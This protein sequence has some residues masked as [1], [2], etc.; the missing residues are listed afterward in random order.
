MSALEDKSI[1]PGCKYSLILAYRYE[2]VRWHNA[3]WHAKCAFED[4]AAENVRLQTELE[5]ARGIIRAAH[6]TQLGMIKL[7]EKNSM[8]HEALDMFEKKQA[9]WLASH[10]ADRK[11]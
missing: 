7:A 8:P 11:R 3:E 9:A 5:E 2:C 4:A 10:P 1:C 6:D